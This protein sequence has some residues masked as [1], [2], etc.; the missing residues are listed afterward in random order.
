MKQLKFPKL[1]KEKKKKKKVKNERKLLVRELDKLVSKIVRRNTP[2]CVI[3]AGTDRLQAGHLFSRS[4]YS[5]R[6]SFDNVF[7]QCSACNLRH[8][9][10]PMPFYIWFI[11][12][13]G[14][15]KMV[16]VYNDW[17]QVSHFKTNDLRELYNKLLVEYGL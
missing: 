17:K 7:T 13:Q 10:D 14:L 11:D 4:H 5:M 3:C 2:Y 15:E 6:W 16:Q 12:T 9:Y 1:V 8:E